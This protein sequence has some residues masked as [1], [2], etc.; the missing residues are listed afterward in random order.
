MLDDAVGPGVPGS[1]DEGLD[2]KRQEEK[3][4]AVAIVRRKGNLRSSV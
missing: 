2:F 3:P 4:R 1:R